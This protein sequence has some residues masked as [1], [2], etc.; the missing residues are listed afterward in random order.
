[1]RAEGRI[2]THHHIVPPSYERTLAKHRASTGGRAL[3]HWSA[4]ADLALM[5]SA[6]IGTAI[7][8][9]SMPGV[10]FG[11]DREARYLARQF[12]EFT[13]EVV[14]SRP[15]RFGFF[16][17]LTLPDIDGALAEAAYALDVLGADG[18][19]LLANAGGTYLGD[20]A[21]DPLFDELNRRQAVIFVHPTTLPGLEPIEGIPTYAAD[22]MLDTTRAAINLART[23]T[24]QRCPGV[25]IILSHA[26]GF[27]PYVAY[28]VSASASPTGDVATGLAELQRFYFDTALSASPSALPGLLAFA[29]SGHVTY[30]SDWPY[31]PDFAV[32]VFNG[33][34]E[35]YGL[36][37]ETRADIDR[38]TAEKLFPRLAV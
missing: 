21:F 29:H 11:D 7:L 37:I 23:K 19:I 6:G 30:G 8:S 3:P 2:D 24:L 38:K 10:H 33:L 34:Y 32:E 4:E 12:N 22:F 15:N 31:A 18:I 25:K 5:D 35:A 1:M 14:K 28:R 26:G 17:T 20:P 27:L 36:D 16:A 13:A 9:V